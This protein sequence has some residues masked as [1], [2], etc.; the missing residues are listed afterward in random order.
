M[1]E[2]DDRGIGLGTDALSLA[3]DSLAPPAQDGS[4][5]R[6]AGEH[7]VSAEMRCSVAHA[8]PRSTG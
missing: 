6:A 2:D 5:E 7:R 1:A 4:G 8:E 3:R